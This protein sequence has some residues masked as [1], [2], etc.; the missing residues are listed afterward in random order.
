MMHKLFSCCIM[1][2]LKINNVQKYIMAHHLMYNPSLKSTGL[3]INALV[4][5]GCLIVIF[6]LITRMYR[7]AHWKISDDIICYCIQIKGET[8]LLINGYQIDKENHIWI[9]NDEDICSECL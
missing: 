5:K 9:G 3:K 7:N 1:M 4:T 2:Y 6:N 8:I